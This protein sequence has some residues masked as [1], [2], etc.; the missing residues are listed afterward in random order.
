M[1][2]SGS[3]LADT[4]APAD[5]A[6]I[7][8]TA[9]GGQ[10]ALSWT[11]PSDPDFASVKITW[12]PLGGSPAQPLSLAA[13]GASQAITGLT[14][15]TAYTFTLKSVDSTGN[16][17]P[18]A[19]IDATPAPNLSISV[20]F[21]L[22]SESPISASLPTSIAKGSL[23]EFSVAQ[24]FDSYAW[25]LD[26]DLIASTRSGSIDTAGLLPKS[27]TLTLVALMTGGDPSSASYRFSVV[28]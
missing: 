24:V 13:P 7:T 16:E 6:G 23:L 8:A 3:A 14:N 5:P 22:G 11:N 1:V 19:T 26:G 10:V 28:N 25:Y 15:G 18:G 27:Y 12:A 21:D 2:R 9:S 4:T 17:S 20:G